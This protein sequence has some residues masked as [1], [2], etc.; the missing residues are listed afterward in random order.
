MALSEMKLRLYELR[1]RATPPKHLKAHLGGAQPSASG[2]IV[3]SVPSAPVAML[4]FITPTGPE[5]PVRVGRS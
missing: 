3:A 1:L 4:R 2:D 5:S